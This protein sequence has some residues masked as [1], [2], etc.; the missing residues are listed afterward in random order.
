MLQSLPVYQH[1]E[2]IITALQKR[3]VVIVAGETGSG[4]SVC[5]PIICREAGYGS[6]GRIAV[7]QPRRIAAVSLATYAASLSGIAPGESVGYRVRYRHS[8]RQTSRIVY[9]TDGILLATLADDPQLTRYDVV[10]L[11]EAH[12]RSVNIDFLLGYLRMLLGR[13]PDLHLIIASATPDI[14]LFERIFN[15]APVISVTAAVFLLTCGIVP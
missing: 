8:V 15:G 2:E 3:Q 4:K 1:R 6:R 14:R 11:D 7:T 9:M 12:E 5:L 13:R 10:I